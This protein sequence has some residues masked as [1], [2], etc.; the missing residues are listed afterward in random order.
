MAADVFEGF[1]VEFGVGIGEDD[2]VGGDVFHGS[3]YGSDLTIAGGLVQEFDLWVA[4][5]D[6]GGVVCGAVGDKDEA[7]F[8]GGIV[9]RQ[10]VEDF[11]FDVVFFVVGGYDD[12]ECGPVAIGRR[13]EMACA[14]D[15]FAQLDEEEQHY[16]VAEK[17]VKDY[18]HA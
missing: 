17:G 4:C 10:G 18:E 13:M 5:N 3:V 15:D 1:V 8:C 16:S 7:N 14:F 6:D 12:G 2:D 9:E 11:F